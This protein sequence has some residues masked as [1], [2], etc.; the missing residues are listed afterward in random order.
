MLEQARQHHTA[1]EDALEDAVEQ[2]RLAFIA[3]YLADLNLKEV[4]AIAEAE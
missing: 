3:F 1:L 4:D 2:L